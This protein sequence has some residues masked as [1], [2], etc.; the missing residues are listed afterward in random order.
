MS[1]D[2]INDDLDE[3]EE[4]VDPVLAEQTALETEIAKDGDPSADE[5]FDNDVVCEDDVCFD[6]H[7]EDEAADADDFAWW[8][9]FWWTTTSMTP[10]LTPILLLWFMLAT[11]GFHQAPE[12]FCD[13]GV[14]F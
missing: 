6:S 14:W 10:V 2:L 3:N 11:H 12:S 13:G 7:G 1:N 9:M 8:M 5:E 4:N